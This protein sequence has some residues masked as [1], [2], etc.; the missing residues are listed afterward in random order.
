MPGKSDSGNLAPESI[1]IKLSS[2]SIQYMFFPTS[3]SPPKAKIAV[4]D[5]KA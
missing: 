4:S 1:I 3:P 5:L 2:Y